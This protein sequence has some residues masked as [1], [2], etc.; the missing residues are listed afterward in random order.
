MPGDRGVEDGPRDQRTALEDHVLVGR[1]VL[2]GRDPRDALDRC[3]QIVDRA[4]L[5][6]DLAIHDRQAHRAAEILGVSLHSMRQ[7]AGSWY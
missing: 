5:A 1:R 3:K 6:H 7:I 2:R 4:V